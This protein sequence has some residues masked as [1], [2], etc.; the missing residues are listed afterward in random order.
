[1]DHTY[2]EKAIEAL[3]KANARIDA[4]RFTIDEALQWQVAYNRIHSLI[5]EGVAILEGRS[6]DASR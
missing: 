1:M 4:E 2:I 5:A 3:E 6:G